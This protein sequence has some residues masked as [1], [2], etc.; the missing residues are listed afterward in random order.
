MRI[1]VDLVESLP[2]KLQMFGVPLDGPANVF[3]DNQS[4]TNAASIGAHTLQKKHNAACSH[5]QVRE[6]SA[7]EMIRVGHMSGA[8]YS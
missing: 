2:F 1:A 4:V 3:W 8:Y 7:M 5:H 6:V